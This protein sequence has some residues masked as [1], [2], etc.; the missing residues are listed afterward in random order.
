MSLRVTRTSRSFELSKE[1]S[2]NPENMFDILDLNLEHHGDTYTI[3]PKRVAG[4]TNT[5]CKP[6][7]NSERQ[8]L[9]HWKE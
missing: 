3:C 4:S 5:N 6:A 1:L 7:G 8:S 2:K 9:K